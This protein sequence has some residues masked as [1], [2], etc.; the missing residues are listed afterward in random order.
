MEV[1]FIIASL[2]FGF[3]SCG[4]NDDLEPVVHRY[5]FDLGGHHGLVGIGRISGRVSWTSVDAGRLIPRFLGDPKVAEALARPAKR[6]DSRLCR[7]ILTELSASAAANELLGSL[8]HAGDLC[9][10]AAMPASNRVSGIGIDIERL[11]RKLSPRLSARI[12]SQCPE[13][14]P[15]EVWAVLEAIY[16]ADPIQPRAGMFSYRVEVSP[17]SS[18][19]DVRSPQFASLTGPLP[20]GVG[21]LSS[22]PSRSEGRGWGRGAVPPTNLEFATFELA[23]HCI[24]LAIALSKPPTG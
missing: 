1:Q 23:E 11:D 16:K 13:L 19:H 18:A 6:D 5:D 21:S 9:V 14:A 24:A 17:R 15:I 20:K 7:R 10:A 22:L 2:E 4:L 8:G 12:K 3:N